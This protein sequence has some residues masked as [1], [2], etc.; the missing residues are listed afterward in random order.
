MLGLCFDHVITFGSLSVSPLLEA[1]FFQKA[2][3]V[4]GAGENEKASV[5]FSCT[6]LHK[7][8]LKRYLLLYI[9]KDTT[10]QT[11]PE[12]RNNKNHAMLFLFFV[13]ADQVGSREK[14]S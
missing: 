12:E 2:N 5:Q 10:P 6:S 1:R 9:P 13:K 7:G 8:I 11:K 3:G 14:L 4:N